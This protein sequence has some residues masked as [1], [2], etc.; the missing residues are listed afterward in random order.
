MLV[1]TDCDCNRYVYSGGVTHIYCIWKIVM[2]SQ[3]HTVHV[4]TH[5]APNLPLVGL[6]FLPLFV[7][8]LFVLL[9]PLCPTFSLPTPCMQV[10]RVLWPCFLSSCWITTWRPES[11]ASGT[12]SS[13]WASPSAV[14]PWEACCSLSSGSLHQQ[15]RF[16]SH[17]ITVCLIECRTVETVQR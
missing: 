7:V 5:V 14:P 11:S 17:F 1:V 6:T 12:A 13:P 15:H 10:S 4:A 16:H 8:F 9:L 2:L 3:R